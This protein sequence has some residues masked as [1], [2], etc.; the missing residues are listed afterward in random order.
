MAF[1]SKEKCTEKEF[2]I[3]TSFQPLTLPLNFHKSNKKES[4]KSL[5]TK[6]FKSKALKSSKLTTNSLVRK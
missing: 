5:S 6:T 4:E 3:T 1:G 2:S